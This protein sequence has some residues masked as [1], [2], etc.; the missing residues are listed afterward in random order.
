M[1][2]CGRYSIQRQ[3]LLM[4]ET[5]TVANVLVFHSHHQLTAQAST[6][7]TATPTNIELIEENDTLS[8]V[9]G[10]NTHTSSGSPMELI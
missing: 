3:G 5:F 4:I 7:S 6:P 1:D 10:D 2:K 9:E 8:F